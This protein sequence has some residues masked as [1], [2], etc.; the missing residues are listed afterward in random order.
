LSEN[1]YDLVVIGAGP[2]GYVAAIRAAQL[3]MSVAIVE[4][5]PA[6][7]GTCSNWGCIPTK[8]LLDS[9]EFYH[10]AKHDFAKHGLKVGSIDIDLPALLKRKDGV[11][12]ANANGIAYL[13]KKNKI[14]HVKGTARI[15]S[16][17]SV[18]V[19]ASD[20]DKTLSTKRV[21]IATGSAPIELP[22]FKYDGKHVVSSDHAINLPKIPEKLLII[23][24]GVI[25]LELGSVWARL[26]S[27]VQVVEFL[28]R[29]APNMDKEMTTAL[30]KLLEKQGFKF[31]FKTGAQTA[32]IANGKVKVDW[33]SGDEKGVEEADVVLVAVGRKPYTQG[34]GLTEL[35]VEIDKRGFVQVDAHY[36]TKVPGVYAIGDVIGGM[37]LAHKAEEEGY[38]AVELMAGKAGHVNYNAVPNVIYTNPELAS[39]GYGEDDAKAKG[40][41]IKVGKFPFMANGRARA[42]GQTDGFVKVI[43]DAKTDRL[44]GVHILA[45]RASD[46]IAEAA[47]AIEFASSVEDIARSVHAHPTLAE[48]F[49]E[50]AMNVE[51][52][53]I[54]I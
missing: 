44:L 52:Q 39:V 19:T 53:A 13:M 46:M 17:N 6:L 25:G 14:A 10:Q 16:A 30:Q 24:A 23:G 33:A 29:I 5:E 31:K 37:M 20:G 26:G 50:A 45:P 28:D 18:V 2:G 42:M 48:A 3:G 7:G 22:A 4:K 12:S 38:A 32:T 47:V 49:K 36:Q 15:A 54:H 27:Q 51:K 43:G 1:N 40:F 8:A 35:G 9:S 11:V 34:L 21:L 41:D